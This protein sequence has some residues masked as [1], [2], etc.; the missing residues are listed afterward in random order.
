LIAT[1]GIGEAR[2]VRLAARWRV[3]VQRFYRQARSPAFA[4]DHVI[5]YEARGLC[6]CR[7]AG[8]NRSCSRCGERSTRAKR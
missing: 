3:V 1:H 4:A 2:A 5:K 6:P 7:A 8:S